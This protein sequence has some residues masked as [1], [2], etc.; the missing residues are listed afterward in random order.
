MALLVDHLVYAV[1]DLGAGVAAMEKLLGVR[2]APG[3]RHAGRGTHNALL[4][5]DAGAYLEIIAPDPEQPD[6]AMPRAF[7]L[8]TLREPR[9]VTWAARTRHIDQQAAD[10]RLEGYDP[11]PV[12]PMSRTLP[13]GSVLHWR[14]TQPP[15]RQGDGVVPFLIEWGPGPHPSETAPHGCRL[16]S[17]A[18]EH[19]HPAEIDRMLAA[20]GVGLTVTE[21]GRPALI[22]TIECPRGTVVLT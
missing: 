17:L 19:P 2:A 7:G 8:D 12:A 5:L 6:P 14:L 21:A 16:V 11:G 13:D 22:A 1:P 15:D 3:G 10:S 4:S 18:A 9:L 20:L